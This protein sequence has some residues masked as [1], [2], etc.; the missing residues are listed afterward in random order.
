MASRLRGCHPPRGLPVNYTFHTVNDTP[1]KITNKR[2]WL[3]AAKLTLATA[4]E[5]AR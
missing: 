1:D 5:I 3:K 2:L 4:L